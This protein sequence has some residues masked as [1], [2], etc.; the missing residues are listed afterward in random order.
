MLS[1]EVK[2]GKRDIY[3]FIMQDPLASRKKQKSY[4]LS[5]EN[6]KSCLNLDAPWYKGLD[7]LIRSKIS[8]MLFY[9]VYTKI[10][11]KA[12]R[13]DME[14]KKENNIKKQ[15]HSPLISAKHH[16]LS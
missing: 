14:K 10:Q 3:L 6:R 8:D 16:Q 1:T 15:K 2:I 9:Y 7:L 11:S 4:R 12:F 13:V 5:H